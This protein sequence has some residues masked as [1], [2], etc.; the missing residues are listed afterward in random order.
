MDEASL[1]KQVREGR[2]RGREGEGRGAGGGEG[3]GGRGRE[4]L[5][6]R[7]GGGAERRRRGTEHGGRGFNRPLVGR[8]WPGNVLRGSGDSKREG[9]EGRKARDGL[10]DRRMVKGPREGVGCKRMGEPGYCCATS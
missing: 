4:G 10:D 9:H 5:R 2:G 7:G 1:A 8:R 3:E 6:R